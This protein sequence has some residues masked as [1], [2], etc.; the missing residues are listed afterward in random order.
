MFKVT[1]TDE[2]NESTVLSAKTPKALLKLIKKYTSAKSSD[3]IPIYSILTELGEEYS[4][5]EEYYNNRGF[6]M[7]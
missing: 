2:M 7:G 5:Y 4:S 6:D 3:S 1:I